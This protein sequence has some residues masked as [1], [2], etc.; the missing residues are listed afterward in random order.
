MAKWRQ[1]GGDGEVRSAF[2][3]TDSDAELKFK[4]VKTPKTIIT[5]IVGFRKIV[6]L[7]NPVVRYMA[8]GQFC[9]LANSVLQI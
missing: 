3:D 6:E 7:A 9:E 1:Q 2:G 8:I 4:S 5:R